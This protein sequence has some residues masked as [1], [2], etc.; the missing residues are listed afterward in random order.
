LNLTFQRCNIKKRP[1][2]RWPCF[3]RNV[4]FYLSGKL[5]LLTELGKCLQTPNKSRSH[6]LISYL[7]RSTELVR[8]QNC[9]NSYEQIYKS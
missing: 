6:G 2:V 1:S 9:S 3:H 5:Y 8:S 4:Y 7:V